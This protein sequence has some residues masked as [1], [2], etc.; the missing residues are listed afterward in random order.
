MNEWINEWKNNP[1]RHRQLFD[2]SLV[3][4]KPHIHRICLSS[5]RVEQTGRK[6]CKQVKIKIR[7]EFPIC[8]SSHRMLELEWISRMTQANPPP[9][10]QKPWPREKWLAQE[11]LWKPSGPSH[12][13]TQWQLAQC[14]LKHSPVLQNRHDFSWAENWASSGKI[15]RAKLRSYIVHVIFT[16]GSLW[17]DDSRRIRDSMAGI[18]APSTSRDIGSKNSSI[19][20]VIISFQRQDDIQVKSRL[21][22]S[23]FRILA[24]LILGRTG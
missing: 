23:V 17:D 24:P 22:I 4:F 7:D 1:A 5:K 8:F 14:S 2:N 21:S 3:I 20:L 9:Q 12:A 6:E 16:L 13:F 11:P 19:R 15:L 18:E 10:M